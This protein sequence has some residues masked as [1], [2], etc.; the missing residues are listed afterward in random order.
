M[1]CWLNRADCCEFKTDRMVCERRSQIFELKDEE[2]EEEYQAFHMSKFIRNSKLT[3][4]HFAYIFD[5]I[6][7]KIHGHGGTS[8]DIDE[9]TW[10]TP[11]EY[12]VLKSSE[13]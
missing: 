4:K 1:D 5:V 2:E 10:I 3:K 12:Q 8:I 6:H 11:L 13:A 7:G 9:K